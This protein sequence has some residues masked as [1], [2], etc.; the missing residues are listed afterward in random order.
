MHQYERLMDWLYLTSDPTIAQGQVV[1]SEHVARY[2]R[3]HKHHAQM[4]SLRCLGDVTN[5]DMSVRDTET[6]IVKQ[7]SIRT[8]THTALPVK[9]R[10][11]CHVNSPSWNKTEPWTKCKN[12]TEQALTFVKFSFVIPKKACKQGIHPGFKTQG[13]RH[14]KSKTGVPVVPRK[15][16]CPPKFFFKK[17]PTFCVFQHGY[18][19]SNIFKTKTLA[20][21]MH[22]PK[23]VVLCFWILF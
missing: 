22:L 16:M 23:A 20:D 14:Q 17:F 15:D 12:W 21:K 10:P 4:S 1:L 3:V 18:K 9:T 6:T 11:G 13:I 8:A 19:E 5:K 2:P 7:Q